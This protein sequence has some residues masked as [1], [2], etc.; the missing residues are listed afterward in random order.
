MF[1]MDN[2]LQNHLDGMLD[3]TRRDVPDMKLSGEIHWIDVPGGKIRVIKLTPPNPSS[4]RPLVFVPGW[5]TRPE[6]FRDFYQVIHGET[7]CYYVETR[8]KNS[9]CMDRA[10]SFSLADKAA[11]VLS[12]IDYFGLAGTDY[13]LFGT[14]WGATIITRGL[15]DNLFPSAAVILFDPMH[16]LWAS[17]WIMHWVA[18]LT[19]IFLLRMVRPIVKRIALRGMTEEVQR[20]RTEAFIDNAEL[21]K[22]KKAAV[23]TVDFEMFGKLSGINRPVFV[24]NGTSD[25]IHEPEHYPKI[26]AE[27][28]E[29]TFFY[30][31]THESNRERLMGVICREFAK[32]TGKTTVPE[33]IAPFEKKID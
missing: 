22:W 26:A 14:C 18:P 30:M 2:N 20:A 4:K 5:G 31:G 7:V 32:I 25:K 21:W 11:D 23:Q 24:V 10:A 8:E 17:R 3:K 9:S 33:T 1:T 28:P 15:M 29:S 6:E 16:S 12:A 27:L 13:V 19:P